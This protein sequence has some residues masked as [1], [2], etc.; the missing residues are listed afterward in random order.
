[1]HGLVGTQGFRPRCPG[2][3]VTRGRLPQAERGLQRHESG[4]WYAEPV[5][6]PRSGVPVS[7]LRGPGVQG[8]EARLGR[9]PVQVSQQLSWGRQ[10]PHGDPGPESASGSGSVGCCRW[11]SR[12]SQTRYRHESPGHRPCWTGSTCLPWT[13]TSARGVAPYAA[14][15]AVAAGR[16]I[17]PQHGQREALSG[18]A[19][20]V[21]CAADDAEGWGGPGVH[22]RG[23]STCQAAHESLRAAV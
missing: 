14:P 4:A 18:P 7:V 15:G 21:S 9:G 8:W 19:R 10:R 5:A 16:E 17:W 1:M 11:V 23:P 12:P 6:G 22:R 20:K 13:R 2:H 3:L